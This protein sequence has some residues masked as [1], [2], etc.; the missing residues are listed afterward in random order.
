MYLSL[1]ATTVARRDSLAAVAAFL[2]ADVSA[3]PGLQ[4]IKPQAFVLFLKRFWTCD[5][6]LMLMRG[7]HPKAKRR[8]FT[9]PNTHFLCM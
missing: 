1:Q 6:E 4:E 7:P 2:L 3:E 8:F 5:S 9:F